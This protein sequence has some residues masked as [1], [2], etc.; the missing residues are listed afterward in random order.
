LVTS[1][2]TTLKKSFAKSL[3]LATIQAQIPVL[4]YVPFVVKAAAAD[5]NEVVEDIITR[6]RAGTGPVKRDLLQIILG[7]NKTDPVAFPEQRVRD[8][9]KLFM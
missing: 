7:A 9:I 3:K 2:D 1:G 8:E 4:S 5:T 6:R